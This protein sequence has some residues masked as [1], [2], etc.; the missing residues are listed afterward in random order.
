[1]A[2]QIQQLKDEALDLL[3]TLRELEPLED[4][5]DADYDEV[6]TDV[7]WSHHQCRLRLGILKE[8]N[9]YD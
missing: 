8:R 1:M 2:T 4:Y 5:S 7:K 3:I 9:Y 6:L